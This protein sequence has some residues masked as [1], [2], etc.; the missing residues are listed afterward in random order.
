MNRFFPLRSNSDEG[1]LLKGLTCGTGVEISGVVA[2]VVVVVVVGGGR[3]VWTRNSS[4]KNTCVSE[5]LI[6]ID[7][8]YLHPNSITHCCV[9]LIPCNHHHDLCNESVKEI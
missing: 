1:P 5:L 6:K 8:C 2:T 3:V 9:S 7:L 4:S